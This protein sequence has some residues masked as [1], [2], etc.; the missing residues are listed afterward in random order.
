MI[1]GLFGIFAG[2]YIYLHPLDAYLPIRTTAPLPPAVG[3]TDPGEQALAE[4]GRTIA[5][6]SGC[7]NCHSTPATRLGAGAPAPL[8]GGPQLR[9]ALF[10]TAYGR[11]LTPNDSGLAGWSELE[12][13]RAL[14]SGRS[15]DGRAIHWQ[16]MPWDHYSNWNEEDLQ[17]LVFYLNIWPQQHRCLIA[18]LLRTTRPGCGSSSGLRAGGLAP[19]KA[20]ATANGVPSAGTPFATP[21]PRSLREA[22][23]HQAARADSAHSVGVNV[24]RP[25]RP[26]RRPPAQRVACR[27]PGPPS[28]RG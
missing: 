3:I 27:A 28:R 12:L 19:G 11:N 16:A 5:T 24:H 18:P 9:S 14:R 8:S 2:F 21:H 26:V 7:A 22:P 4:R 10:G 15:R 23:Q 17:A 6:I 1:V 25:R 20:P 13:K